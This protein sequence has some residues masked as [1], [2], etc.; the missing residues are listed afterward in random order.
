M[1]H[2]F[3]E[4]ADVD[5]TKEPMEVGPT[6]H[7]VMGGVEVEPDTGRGRREGAVRGWRSRPAA[8]TARTASAATRCPTS[9]FSAGALVWV[10]RTTSMVWPPAAR[11]ADADL[12]AA[13]P[14]RHRS[15]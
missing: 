3:K 12:D 11:V 6:C 4:L 8:C 9:W 10:P 13:S 2:Q 15:A 7:Y 1:Y 5:I 14:R